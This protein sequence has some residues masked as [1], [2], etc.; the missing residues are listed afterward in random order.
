MLVPDGASLRHA[1]DALAC[2]DGRIVALG[3]PEECARAL[4]DEARRIVARDA[5]LLPGFID[6]HVHVLAAAAAAAGV[7]CSPQAVSSVAELLDVIARG[8]SDRQPGAWVRAHGY[9]ETM[10]AERR[11]PTRAELDAAAP[12]HP[13]RLT[14][15]SGHAEVLNSRALALAG[16]D[17]SVAE[18]PGAAFGRSLDDGRLDG[19]LLGMAERIEAAMPP[20]GSV[21]VAAAVGAWAR[22]QL[23]EGI[24]TLVDAGPR[25]GLAEWETLAGLVADGTLP[26][27]LVVME[28]ADHL[29][30]L[31][32]HA[33]GG[34]VRRGEVKVQPRVLEG[35]AVGVDDLAA[36]VRR[37]AEVGRRVAVHAPTVESVRAALDAFRAAGDPRGQRIEHAPLLPRDLVEA[38]AEA[39]V[40]VVAQ[41]GLLTEVTPRYEQLLSPTE[42]E[43]LHPWR[44]VLGAG[45]PLAFSSDAPVSRSGPLAASAAASISRPATLAPEQALRPLE[46]LAAWTSGAAAVGGLADRGRLEV[47]RVADL[48]VVE[49]PLEADPASCRVVVTVAGGEVLYATRDEDRRYLKG[50][51]TTMYERWAWDAA[52]PYRAP[53]PSPQRP[54][55]AVVA[56][57]HGRGERTEIHEHAGGHLEHEH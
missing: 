19:L 11:H 6:A 48:V 18:P 23:A 20:P 50:R 40:A 27:R 31:P 49:G 28:G 13:V 52:N 9:E 21:A 36:V 16:I 53:R 47:G 54:P 26:Q 42:R 2:V 32:E 38:I 35:D 10:L 45:A 33:A 14:H 1:H 5:Y 29:G 8:A 3:T 25:N 57:D 46:A 56:H 15:R 22:E 30:E 17:E 43:R 55:D 39:G 7:D 34:R 4:P 12:H 24:T 51:P 41:P 37:S 44:D